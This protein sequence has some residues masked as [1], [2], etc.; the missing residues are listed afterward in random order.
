[1]SAHSPLGERYVLHRWRSPLAAVA[2]V[3]TISLLQFLLHDWYHEAL[4]ISDR[5]LDTAAVAVVIVLFFAMQRALSGGVCR[6]GSFGVGPDPKDEDIHCPGTEACRRIAVPELREVPTYTQVLSRHLVSVTEQTEKAACD[7]TMRLQTIDEV[8]TEL[9]RFVA[10]EAAE[11]ESMSE[12]SARQVDENR[13]L[14]ARLEAF[15][16]RRIEEA[17][18]DEE[19]AAAAVRE[20]RSL[21]SLVDLIRHIAGQTNLL[22]LNA[23]IEAARAG[24]SG[25]GF[26][27]VADEVRKLSQETEAAVRKINDGIASVAASIEGQYR[28]K[29]ANSHI[30]EERASLHRFAEQLAS[31]GESYARLSERERNILASITES[32]GRLS[33]MFVHAMS[34]V[35]FQ[36][37]TRQQIEHVIKALQR[38]DAHTGAI[39]N[40]LERGEGVQAEAAVVPLS[41]QLTEIFEHYVMNQQRDA[42]D[43]A[44]RGRNMPAA[45]AGAPAGNV[46]LF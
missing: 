26:A 31:L 40:L 42:H 15:I 27:V 22:A 18:L 30:G 36:D 13:D 2:S 6:D 45:A 19:R 5:A 14:I 12:Q 4:G 33:E 34:S 7:L 38:L 29:A 17:H 16:Q 1:M 25:R 24:E 41:T 3:V 9:N 11:S 32:S 23:A 46:E 39:A 20:T 35:Q 43:A 37:V 8:V 10:S 21:Q 44:M 28:D